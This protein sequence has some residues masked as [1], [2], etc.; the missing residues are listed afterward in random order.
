MAGDQPL[1]AAVHLPAQ[2]RPG[3]GSGGGRHPAELDDAD[4]QLDPESAYWAAVWRNAIPDYQAYLAAFAASAAAGAQGDRS[5]TWSRCCSNPIRSVRRA[6]RRPRRRRSSPVRPARTGSTPRAAIDDAYCA[7]LAPPPTLVC[8]PGF[9]SVATDDGMACG[10]FLPPP[11]LICPPRFHP[12]RRAVLR[13]RHPAAVLPAGIPS[14]LARRRARLRARR[15]AAADLPLRDPPGLERRRLRLWRQ[16][17]PAPAVPRRS[18]ELAQWPMVLPDAAAAVLP[19]RPDAAVEFRQADLRRRAPADRTRPLPA[20]IHPVASGRPCC[21][22]LRIPGP[23][24][25]LAP[26]IIKLPTPTPTPEPR[27]PNPDAAADVDA[28]AD[29]D[30][31]GAASAEADAAADVDSDAAADAAVA[32]RPRRRRADSDAD[33]EVRYAAADV[34]PTPKFTPL[35]VRTPLVTPK[36]PLI[37]HTAPPIVIEKPMRAAAPRPPGPNKPAPAASSLRPAPACQGVRDSQ[38]GEPIGSPLRLSKNRRRFDDRR[39][40]GDKKRAKPV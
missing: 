29:A 6:L 12:D 23:T 38:R 20:R 18:A 15:A 2:P 11:V 25:T 32:G 33:A 27:P 35:I 24:P 5:R 17:A 14:D 36:T 1:P 16:S 10:P 26:P 8:P 19:A 9:V 28:A 21:I 22:P 7:P 40:L 39:R 13:A 30:P 3:A 4:R 34:D 31:H 37:V